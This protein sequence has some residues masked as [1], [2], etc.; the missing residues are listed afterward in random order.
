MSPIARCHFR[1][2]ATDDE[3]N[4]LQNAKLWLYQP[5]TTTAVTDAWSAATAGTPVTYLITN[6]QGEG[7]CWFDTPQE[8]DVSVTDNGNSAYYPGRQ[9]VTAVLDIDPDDVALLASANAMSG[10]NNF[11]GTNTFTGTSVFTGAARVLN[12]PWVDVRH[13]IYGAVGDYSVDDAAHLQAA[14]N[15]AQNLPGAGAG[16]RR[17]RWSYGT[18]KTLS[19]LSISTGS[20]VVEGAGRNATIFKPTL[21]SGYAIDIETSSYHTFRDMTFDGTNVTGTGRLLRIG[22]GCSYN[23]FERV[24]FINCAGAYAAE[25]FG[26]IDNVFIDCRWSGNA[27]HLNVV[28]STNSGYP[29]NENHFRSCKFEGATASATT[30]AISITN[31]YGNTFTNCLIQDNLGLNAVLL[32][33]TA[34]STWLSSIGNKFRDCWF[35]E[36]GNSQANSRDISIIGA[37]AGTPI[38]GTV[39]EASI[40]LSSFA[41]NPGYHIFLEN[42]RSTYIDKNYSNTGA[43][44]ANNGGNTRTFYGDNDVAGSVDTAT[45]LVTTAYNATPTTK[46]TGVAVTAAGVHAALVTLGLIAP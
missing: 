31:S 2:N 13:P 34:G 24:N 16:T 30:A 46:P 12:D 10:N 45:N 22:S 15:A 41:N 35:E 6:N 43:F 17:V 36:N 20:L 14:F 27:Q 23:V 39:L 32:R 9:S 8:V 33:G 5:G 29:S 25:L 37:A 3:G 40:W 42:A 11:S 44:V 38:I 4:A 18:Y 26:A 21:S 19:S 1:Y 28:D 7:E